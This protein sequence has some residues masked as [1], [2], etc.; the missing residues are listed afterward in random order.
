MRGSS[1]TIGYV[2]RDRKHRG[3]NPEIGTFLKAIGPLTLKLKRWWVLP[4]L[5]LVGALAAVIGP[6]Y[7]V[8]PGW[9]WLRITAGSVAALAILADR[10]ADYFDKKTAELTFRESERSAEKS[11]GALNVF[12][13]EALEAMFLENVAR[14]EAIKTLR[15]TIARTAAACV[16]DGSR[17]SYYPLRRETGGTRILDRPFHATE[18]GRF[19]KPDRPFLESEDPDHEV[20]TVLDRAD[21]EPEV[22]SDDEEVHGVDWSKKKYRTFYSVPVKAN[23][24]QL[25]FLSVNN[26]KV[27]AIGGPQRATVL[28]MARALA[29]VMAAHKGP[30]FLNEQAAY[31]RVSGVSANVSGNTEEVPT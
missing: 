27:G 16:G 15:R 22:R 11:V 31:Y 21:E 26:S 10:V 17:A 5:A 2:T 13:S 29:L 23:M 4:I 18:Y 24:V 14:T 9:A 12:L 19:D 8:D 28:A 3:S 20:W 1:A 30:R 7:L 6:I 25:G